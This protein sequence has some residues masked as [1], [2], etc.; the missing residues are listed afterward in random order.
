MFSGSDSTE[1]QNYTQWALN[2]SAYQN[3]SSENVDWAALAQQWIIMKEAGPPVPGQATAASASAPKTRSKSKKDTL[4]EAGE[5]PM[6]VENEKD[7]NAAGS[8]GFESSSNQA[9]VT[10]SWNWN[11]QQPW[12]WNNTWSAT[13]G[14][15]PPGSAPGVVKAPL[16]PTPPGFNQFNPAHDTANETTNF[17]GYVLCVHNLIPLIFRV[18]T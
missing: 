5:A 10:D 3:V 11:Q 13:S 16:L 12:G 9:P 17:P 14:V 18:I 6:D 15:P 4:T 7:E 1:S 2:P 8:Q